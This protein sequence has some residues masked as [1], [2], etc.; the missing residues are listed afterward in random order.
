MSDT[1]NRYLRR[2]S[3]WY[4]ERSFDTYNTAL[5]TH[6]AIFHFVSLSPIDELN[7]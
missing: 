5:L 1:C 2:T 4:I 6:T 3:I 7:M